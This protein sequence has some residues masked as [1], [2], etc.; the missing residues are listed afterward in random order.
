[1]KTARATSMVTSL[2]AAIVLFLNKE[3]QERKNARNAKERE[4]RKEKGCTGRR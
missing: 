4:R 3:K 2:K 1:M